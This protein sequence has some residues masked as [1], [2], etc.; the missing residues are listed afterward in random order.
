MS[1]RA[2]APTVAAPVSVV[3]P[4]Q[5]PM[6]QRS[7]DCGQHTGG[8]GEC[9][10][11]KKKKI[12]LQRYAS[13]A[14]IAPVAPPIVHEVLRSQGQPLDP[15]TR[16]FMEPRFRQDFSQVR[17]HTDERAAESARAVSAHAYTVGRHVVFGRG[18]YA[19]TTTGGTQLL[20]HELSHVVHQEKSDNGYGRS[21]PIVND[22][23]QELEADRVSGFITDSIPTEEPASTALFSPDV[24]G[25]SLQRQESTDLKEPQDDS[26]TKVS[27]A[28]GAGSTG[29]AM[30][31]P[32]EIQ[33]K[34][35]DAL[36]RLDTITL[37]ELGW[38]PKCCAPC[39]TLARVLG[40]LCEK[41]KNVRH[42]FRLQFY[43]IDVDPKDENNNCEE[44]ESPEAEE[45][46]RF[47]E[48]FGASSVPH[49]LIYVERELKH[50]S[51]Q[52]LGSPDA[53]EEVIADVIKDASTSGAVRGFK[54]GLHLG[55]GDGVLGWLAT[56]LL[57]P[58]ALL[59]GGA[60]SVIGA[61]SGKE[62]GTKALSEDRIKKVM[63]F[64]EGKVTAEELDH[65]LSEDIIDYWVDHQDNYKL[66]IFQKQ[67]LINNL[68]KGFTGDAEERG[69]IK[70]LENSTDSEILQIFSER[71]K[72]APSL[73]TLAAEFQG[74]ER[75]YLDKLLDRLRGRFSVNP[76]LQKTTGLLIDN[77]FVRAVLSDAF[78][79]TQ[80]HAPGKP[81]PQRECGG[82]FI[83]S[84]QGGGLDKE[85]A[86]EEGIDVAT[87]Q[88]AR[89]AIKKRGK[90]FEIAGS[91]HTHP[92]VEPGKGREAPSGADIKYFLQDPA[93]GKEHY[94]VGPFV[95][96][97][98]TRDGT[99]RSLGTTAGLLHVQRIEPKPGQVST[100][101]LG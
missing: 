49:L 5:R 73:V 100:L 81:A 79:R 101:E 52:Y 37:V 9:E 88:L 30:A 46:R 68:I 26:G 66:A 14:A 97:L 40:G 58:V 95:T 47:G 38:K 43:S 61:L 22:K 11:C 78:R 36:F 75:E 1:T 3:T 90:G 77:P 76:P 51:T 65:S 71:N 6:L 2:V 87:G 89:E 7:C 32:K 24:Q 85:V 15:G 53:Y 70:V 98:I 42:P 54:A 57:A 10:D 25:A 93:R 12:P 34:D 80:Q 13:G 86:C 21:I 94:V 50:H 35:L 39:S 20:A 45:S 4:L 27:G 74:E 19:P 55:L 67:M 31:C 41:Y 33:P 28:G 18:R 82:V 8:G 69:I 91:F 64:N 72:D 17:V 59:A 60:G 96:Y 56:V 63:A 29:G 23:N 83:S 84:P 99:V 92:V 44:I 62:K 48:R 16:A